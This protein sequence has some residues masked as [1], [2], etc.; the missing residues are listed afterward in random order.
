MKTTTV[1]E[2]APAFLLIDAKG[3][4]LGKVAAK[5][6]H[7]LRGKHLASF[8][9]HQVHG[10]HVIIINADK[11]SIPPKKIFR[12]TY[13][14]YTGYMGNMKETSLQTMLTEHPERVLEIAIKGMLTNNRLRPRILKR[15]HVYNED[16]HPY[17]DQKVT[18]V[19]V[20]FNAHK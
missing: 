19:S 3:A 6:A 16:T 14:R 12:K 18:V 5:A 9:P 7:I 17:T 20:S 11:L 1:P 13:Y 10:D 8:A 4:T 2:S 15:L